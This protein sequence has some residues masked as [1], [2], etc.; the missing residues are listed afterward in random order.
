MEGCADL[1]AFVGAQNVAV[2]VEGL[3]VA[4]CSGDCS[5][6]A[7]VTVDELILLVNVLLG[8]ASAESCVAGIPGGVPVDV[9][10]LVQAISS[11]LEGC[12]AP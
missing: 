1:G 12:P 9:T 11:V 2:D 7:A 3:A 10:L 4:T 6:D 8:T 5:G